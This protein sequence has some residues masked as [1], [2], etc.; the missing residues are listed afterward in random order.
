M[1]SIQE[2]KQDSVRGAF[3]FWENNNSGKV[4]LTVP[5]AA[6]I[7]IYSG[8]DSLVWTQYLD[9][10]TAWYKCDEKRIGLIAHGKDQLFFE[11]SANMPAKMDS[12]KMI[13]G[14]AL[15]SV[16]QFEQI[17]ESKNVLTLKEF[18]RF[19]HNLFESF[20]VLLEGDDFNLLSNPNPKTRAYADWKDDKLLD[21]FFGHPLLKEAY[22][23]KMSEKSN[24]FEFRPHFEKPASGADGRVA[25][26]LGNGNLIG[27]DFRDG[28]SFVGVARE[29]LSEVERACGFVV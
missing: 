14:A 24:S 19:E 15:I 21:L 12:G 28:G 11:N 7:K 26:F 13:T 5:Q 17:R 27:D 2:F 1:L 9:C 16:S 8:F 3:E 18:E 23:K 29:A 10:F 4:L 22:F 20:K 25:C 6:L